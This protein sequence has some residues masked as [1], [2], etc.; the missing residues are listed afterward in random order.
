MRMNRRWFLAGGAA[1]ASG[2]LAEI[3]QGPSADAPVFKTRHA[4]WQHGYDKAL[5]VLAAN[6][7]TLPRYASPVLIEG[8][9]YPGI[10]LECGPHES[11]LY[12][13]FRPDV[14]RHSHQCFFA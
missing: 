10:W 13:R 8:A 6:V 7:Q 4:T 2:A 12:R 1:A 9:A 5:A 11:L 3:T 14:A